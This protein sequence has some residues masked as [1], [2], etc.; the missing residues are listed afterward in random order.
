MNK[1]IVLT[2]AAMIAYQSMSY[3]MDQEVISLDE[4]IKDLDAEITTKQRRM[5]CITNNGPLI[6][7]SLTATVFALSMYVNVESCPLFGL[8]SGLVF[9]ELY[10]TAAQWSKSFITW[11]HDQP[12]KDKLA[13]AKQIANS[14]EDEGAIHNSLKRL[15]QLKS[16]IDSNEDTATLEDKDTFE[17]LEITLKEKH[18][19]N[20]SK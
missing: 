9:N 3:G 6:P 12:I 14:T 19:S 7:I 15:I 8:V 5:E 13:K 20:R 1:R 17:E 18:Q 2:A 11:Q 4:A 10:P 16:E